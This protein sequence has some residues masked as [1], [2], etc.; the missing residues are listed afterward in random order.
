M[1]I[2][3][4]YFRPQLVVGPGALEQLPE[5]VKDYGKKAFLV[6][7]PFFVGG[8]VYDRVMGYLEDKDVTVYS[9]VSSNPR[10]TDI[11]EGAALMVEKGC[12][13]L[14]TLGGGS[15]IDSA[16]A[17]NTVY[18]NGGSCW[19]YVRRAGEEMRLITKPLLPLVC[20]PT[21]AGTGTE[22][23]RYSVVTNIETHNKG[24]IKSDGVFPTV[25]LIDAELM[26]SMPRKLTALTGI[27]A[28]T[29]AFE[30]YIS[31]TANI[32][33]EIF[34]L[35][36]IELFA[37]SIE[38]ACLDGNDTEARNDMALCSTLA[39]ISLCH[40]ATTL[41]HG[42]GQPLSGLTDAPHGGSI[43]VCLPTVV[44]WTL[45]ECQEKFAKVAR[46]FKPELAALPEAEQAAALPD[47]L[48]ELFDRIIGEHLT[49]S[50]YG[51]TADM[52]EKMAE[53]AL[54]NY[55]GDVTRH[56]KVAT[57]EELMEI[58]NKCL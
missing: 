47:M 7:D 58:I 31:R 37:K 11:D 36:A 29:H 27:D 26:T 13:F 22:A 17:M 9:K 2:K 42:L 38:K 35:R 25:S 3:T 41:S 34:S 43:A 54:T 30:S 24:T 32:F 12:D 56:P 10:H 8:P 55:N 33:S 45:P 50:S 57:K 48:E 28:F 14:V 1:A 49:M 6:I 46:I 23:T 16:K 40:S 44:R 5:V 21:T 39:G 52:V 18:T 15:C 19:E 20:I 51:L 4:F 53:L